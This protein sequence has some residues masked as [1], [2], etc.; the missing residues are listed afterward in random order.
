V[1]RGGLAMDRDGRIFASLQDG[2]VLCLV[3]ASSIDH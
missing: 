1:V 3:A 2:T